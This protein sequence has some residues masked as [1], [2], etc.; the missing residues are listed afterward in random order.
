M[1]MPVAHFTSLPQHC[2]AQPDVFLAAQFA[3]RPSV[4]H[5]RQ[6]RRVHPA[7]VI[8]N[9]QDEKVMPLAFHNRDLHPLRTSGE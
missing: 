7:P 9:A 6:C 5:P 4:K 1:K 3:C 2:Q 8:T